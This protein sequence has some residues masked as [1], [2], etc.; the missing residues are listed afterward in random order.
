MRKT[1]PIITTRK[2]KIK[3]KNGKRRK[4]IIVKETNIQTK[5]TTGNST[6]EAIANAKPAMNKP[7]NISIASLSLRIIILFNYYHFSPF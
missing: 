7:K 2:G 6:R 1:T 3:T 4:A 5:K